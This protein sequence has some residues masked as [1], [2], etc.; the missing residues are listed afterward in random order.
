[1]RTNIK[2]KE[3]P[4]YRILLRLFQSVDLSRLPQHPAAGEG[5]GRRDFVAADP[6]RRHLQYGQSER[7][8]VPRD[9]GAAEGALHE[10]GSG[11]L[12][13]LGGAGDQDAADG[14]SGEQWEG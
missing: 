7:L 9:A 14:V 10:K 5:I 6:G 1:M 4:H 8:C 3:T 11:G 2:T 12:D 13:A